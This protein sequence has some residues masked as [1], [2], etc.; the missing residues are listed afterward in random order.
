VEEGGG[1]G[2]RLQLN[3]FKLIQYLRTSM[4]PSVLALEGGS[5][6]GD[7]E[8]QM[9]EGSG[10]GVCVCLWELCAGNLD[11]GPCIVHMTAKF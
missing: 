3:G 4:D 8:T 5:F 1:G 10:N 11:R 6:T 7:S 9:E 2:N